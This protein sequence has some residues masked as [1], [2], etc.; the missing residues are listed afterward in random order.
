VGENASPAFFVYPELVV[1]LSN[2]CRGATLSLVEWVFNPLL[3]TI[4]PRLLAMLWSRAGLCRPPGAFG[5]GGS[6]RPSV[7]GMSAGAR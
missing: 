5:F 3:S 7:Q 2:H 6:E 4:R 1:S